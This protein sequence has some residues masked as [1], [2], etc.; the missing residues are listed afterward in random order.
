MAKD[1]TGK[2][3]SLYCLEIDH[4]VRRTIGG[5]AVSNGLGW[6]PDGRSMYFADSPTQRVDVFDFDRSA[7]R[8]SGRR[9]L[10]EFGPGEG[11]PDGMTVDV[12]GN[13]W[14]AMW[15]GWTVRQYTPN[16]DLIQVVDVPVSKVTSCA[17]GGPGYGTLYITTA[18][19]DLSATEL[20]REPMA[21]DLFHLEPGICGSPPSFYLG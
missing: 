16:G 17:F 1:S 11:N 6:S 15:D 7:G 3:G 19:K 13:L 14:V 8:L 5:V 2:A 18:S 4:R 20:E 9:P 21:G 12:E 10:I